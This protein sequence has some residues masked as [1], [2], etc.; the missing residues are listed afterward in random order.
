MHCHRN[1]RNSA[2]VGGLFHFLY[3]GHYNLC[4]VHEA[5]RTTPAVVLG[6]SDRV[7]T[8]GNLL[9]ATL[10]LEPNRPLRVKRNFTVRGR[11]SLT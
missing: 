10:A 3:V 11:E 4:R 9:N 6:I 1:S 7:W 5:P 8:I 2:S